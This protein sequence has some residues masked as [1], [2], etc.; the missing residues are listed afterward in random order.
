M[1]SILNHISIIIR[2]VARTIHLYRDL[3]GFEVIWHLEKVGGGKLSAM[4]GI[5]GFE[6]EMV[7]L[8]RAPDGAAVELIRMKAPPMEDSAGF[9]FGH[10]GSVGLSMKVEN[11]DGLHEQLT[12]EGWTPFSPC[13]DLVTPKRV[14]IRAFCFATDEGVTVEL[15]Q[16]M[17]DSRH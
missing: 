17:T 11:I 5:P 1:A 3:L 4:L 14:P 8:Q 16:E 15:F 10:S 12:A 13:M 7:Y 2:D 9:R 6:C